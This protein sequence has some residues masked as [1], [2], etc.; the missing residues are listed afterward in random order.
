MTKKIIDRI[1]LDTGSTDYYDDGISD[2]SET[3]GAFWLNGIDDPE[4]EGRPFVLNVTDTTAWV[5]FYDHAATLWEDRAESII[6]R[7]LSSQVADL[8]AALEDRR[9]Y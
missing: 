6:L 3:R 2:C 7:E 8:R 5:T 9:T 4:G 1:E